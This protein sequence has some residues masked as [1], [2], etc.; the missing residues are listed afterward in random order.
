MEISNLLLGKG[1]ALLNQIRLKRLFK[2]L[3]D[4]VLVKDQDALKNNVVDT[5]MK[6]QPSLYGFTHFSVHTFT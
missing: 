5:P 4:L 2:I 6:A 3:S 1:Q